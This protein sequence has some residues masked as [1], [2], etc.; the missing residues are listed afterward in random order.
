M[1]RACMREKGYDYL[2]RKIVQDPSQWARQS[3]PVRGIDLKR[4]G[5]AMIREVVHF[6]AV[7]GHEPAVPPRRPCRELHHDYAQPVRGLGTEGRG[8]ARPE[9]VQQAPVECMPLVDGH[10]PTGQILGIGG[11]ASAGPLELGIDGQAAVH[12]HLFEATERVL[13]PAVPLH[14]PG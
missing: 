12:E 8:H 13:R 1:F 2:G 7:P 10:S 5:E 6:R 9:L 14:E 3:C 11:E 4:Q